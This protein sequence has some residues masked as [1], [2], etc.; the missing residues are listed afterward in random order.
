MILTKYMYVAELGVALRDVWLL[1]IL[2][3]KSARVM[4]S[5]IQ[6]SEPINN[7]LFVLQ[8]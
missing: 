2:T 7:L 8:P 4:K 5:S 1:H 6:Q 3:L